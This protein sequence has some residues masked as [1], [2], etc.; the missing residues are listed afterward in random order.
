[1]PLNRELVLKRRKESFC[2]L[3]DLV[4]EQK[5]NVREGQEEGET[6]AV[7][8]GSIVDF[9]LKQATKN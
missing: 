5:K 1:M 7:T 2:D 9:K 4:Q 8:V 6:L 3:V